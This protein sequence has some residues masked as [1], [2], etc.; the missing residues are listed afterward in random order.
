MAALAALGVWGYHAAAGPWRVALAVLAPLAAATLWGLFIAPKAARRAPDPLRLALEAVVFGA[1]G[2]ALLHLGRPI[3]AL[4][5]L[6]LSL[7]TALL[8]RRWSPGA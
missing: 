7:G 4:V 3:L 1:A 2:A 5:L 8:V 6:V